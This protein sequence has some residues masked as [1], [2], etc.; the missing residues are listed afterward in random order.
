MY[1]Q[2]CP[3]CG[4]RLNTNYCDIC[5]MKV[6]YRGKKMK[7]YKDPWESSSA[8]REEKGHECVTFGDT[9]K[10]RAGSSAHREEAGHECVSFDIPEKRSPAQKKRKVPS[11]TKVKS[12][13]AAIALL[14]ILPT[15][16]GILEDVVSHPETELEPEYNYEAFVVGEVPQITPA[17]LYDDGQIRITTGGAGEYYDDY[18][19]SVMIQN[20]SQQDVSVMS[21][22]LSVNGY[23]VDC[24]L[25]ADVAAGET[26][27]AFLQL[28]SYELELA[29]ITQ[30]AEI[31]FRLEIYDAQTYEN[32][33][34]S[35]L[36]TLE[37]DI[38]DGFVQPVDD[39]GWEMHIDPNLRVVYQGAEVS[40]FGDCDLMMYMENLSENEVAFSVERVTVNGREVSGFAWNYLLPG[41]RT[42]SSLYLYELEELDITQLSDITEIYLEYTVETTSDGELVDMVYCTTLFNPNALPASA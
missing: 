13:V 2:R 9:R 8:H 30:V 29:G 4:N 18:A 22:L 15:L 6:P 27:Q 10:S 19:L 23:M 37:T 16:F 24:G 5:L 33:G 41:T 7:R 38:A 28:E 35:E 11:A 3:E 26:Q 42:V 31:T 17:E 1:E 32:I 34:L 36:I 20:D 14:S 21:G 39:S 25:Y 40:S 12:I